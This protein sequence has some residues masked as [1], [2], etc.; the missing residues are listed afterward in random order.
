MNTLQTCFVFM[1]NY[2]HACDYLRC[3]LTEKLQY[4]LQVIGMGK[5]SVY[6]AAIVLFL[7]FFAFGLLAIPM[8]HVK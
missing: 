2:F 4:C 8:L 5:P 6:H 3:G 1:L 7:E